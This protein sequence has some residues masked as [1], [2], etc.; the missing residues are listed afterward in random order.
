MRG[1]QWNSQMQRMFGSISRHYDLLNTIMSFG[2]DRVLRRRVLDLL[3]LPGQGRLL[4]VGAGTGK[5]AL[6]AQKRF[7]GALIVAA[8]LTME[9]MRIGKARSISGLCW[10]AADT[11]RLPFADAAFD[12][13]CS[14]FL[15]RNVPDVKAAFVE[16]ARVVKPGG[17]VVCLDTNPPPGSFMKP[18]VHLHLDIVIPL[19]GGL[20]SRNRTAYRYLPESTKAFKTASEV[21]SLM[22]AAGLEQVSFRSYMFGTMSIVK[23]VRPPV[24]PN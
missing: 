15:V 3:S 13:V 6:D 9:M 18:F 10:C 22:E 16:Q 12:A 14:G 1:P 19:V 20:I 21:A 2:M 17:A 7:A 8:D 5:I 11:L 23:G 4:D 24:I